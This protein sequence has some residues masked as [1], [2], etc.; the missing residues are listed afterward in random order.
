MDYPT[1]YPYIFYFNN[2]DDD[3]PYRI[4]IQTYT[5]ASYYV[6]ARFV[7][8][9]SENYT[10]GID[11]WRHLAFVIKDINDGTCTGEFYGNGQMVALT[12]MPGRPRH[13]G[14]AT[15]VNLGSA[16]DGSGSFMDAFYDDFRVYNRALTSTEV[17]SLYNGVEPASANKLLHYDF[18][19]V[20]GLI[21][22]NSSTYEFYHPLL[23]DAEIYKGEAEGYRVV[24][25]KDF[26]LLADSWL[27]EQLWP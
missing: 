17:Q 25:F 20:S 19:E 26:A 13:Y 12:S 11:V 27:E 8:G 24:N 7:D 2:G 15:G 23:T 22:H 14:A 21:A 5:P 10:G 16:N 3:D 1:S 6:R 4:Y 9:Y 18:N